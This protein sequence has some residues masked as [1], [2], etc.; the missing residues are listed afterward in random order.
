MHPLSFTGNFL[1][2]RNEKYFGYNQDCTFIHFLDGPLN[3][4]L[5]F[6]FRRFCVQNTT[7]PPPICSNR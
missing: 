7:P 5:N 6:F 4:S 3:S 1:T 2:L